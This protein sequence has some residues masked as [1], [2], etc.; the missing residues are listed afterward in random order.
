MGAI[1]LWGDWAN[2][3]IDPNGIELLTKLRKKG[4]FVLEL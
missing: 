2:C 1:A 4:I 3:I